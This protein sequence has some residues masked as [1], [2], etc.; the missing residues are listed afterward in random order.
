MMIKKTVGFE[1]FEVFAREHMSFFPS[2]SE[3]QWLRYV[4]SQMIQLN[5]A[6]YTNEIGRHLVFL[7]FLSLYEQ[8][9]CFVCLTFAK[10]RPFPAAEAMEKLKLSDFRLGQMAG[11]DHD[12]ETENEE[13][14]LDSGLRS[15]VREQRSSVYNAIFRIF[16]GES[17]LLVSLLLLPRESL[18]FFDFDQL[19]EA[20][21]PDLLD[22]PAA[23]QPAKKV[24]PLQAMKSGTC[25]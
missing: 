17:G 5:M 11:L 16:G 7:R 25:A 4:W 2:G 24:S 22:Y 21:A 3:L 1:K 20:Y 19:Y 13:S 15:L 23:S 12:I 9:S 10:K 14:L 6:S 18:N 8:M